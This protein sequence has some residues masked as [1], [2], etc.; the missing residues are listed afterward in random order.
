MVAVRVLEGDV[1]VSP[2]AP[3]ERHTTSLEPCKG[4]RR[5][6][7]IRATHIQQEQGQ[8]YFLPAIPAGASQSQDANVAVILG[9]YQGEKYIS[10]QLRSI[11]D[12][13][14]NRISLYISDD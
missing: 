14:Y 8:P 2:P 13:T 7:D 5:K 10:Q 12:Q 6:T 3:S 1:S 11:F 4:P 9:Y